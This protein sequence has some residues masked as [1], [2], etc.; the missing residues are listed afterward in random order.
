MDRMPKLLE[1]TMEREHLEGVLLED[2]VVDVVDDE[3]E[4]GGDDE[5]DGD[6]DDEAMVGGWC[7]GGPPKSIA[8]TRPS[9]CC[10]SIALMASFPKEITD[11]PTDEEEEESPASEDDDDGE[12]ISIHSPFAWN[13]HPSFSYSYTSI[14]E[15]R[16]RLSIHSLSTVSYAHGTIPE[17]PDPLKNPF[18]DGEATINLNGFSMCRM[19]SA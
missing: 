4:D 13:V 1:P 15:P 14:S 9:G 7:P 6:G 3:E 12:D 18:A 16:G 11:S 8:E 17:R 10:L 5:D 19:A 2:E